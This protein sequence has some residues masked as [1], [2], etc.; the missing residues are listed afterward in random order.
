M[1]CTK[2]RENIDISQLILKRL[3]K[4]LRR[5]F[6]KFFIWHFKIKVMI[7][8]HWNIGVILHKDV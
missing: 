5:I 4:I 7:Q 6:L 1:L 2:M 8:S 3:Q